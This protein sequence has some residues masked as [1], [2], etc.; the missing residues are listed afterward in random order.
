MKTKCILL[1]VFFAL[2]AVADPKC[3]L[4]TEGY[5]H[6]LNDTFEFNAE[7]KY[8]PDR[9]KIYFEPAWKAE[10]AI[11]V[12]IDRGTRRMYVM[13]LR[14]PQRSIR[15]LIENGGCSVSHDS[16]HNNIPISVREITSTQDKLTKLTADFYGL[17]FSAHRSAFFI[18]DANTVLVSYVGAQTSIRVEFI[19]GAMKGGNWDKIEAWLQE[20]TDIAGYR[21]W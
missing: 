12:D 5:D 10:S 16:I 14:N 11:Q 20:L 19:P 1:F 13:T 6:V 18:T 15:A 4:S 8:R 9:I 17:E 21:G 7:S 2:P 3:M